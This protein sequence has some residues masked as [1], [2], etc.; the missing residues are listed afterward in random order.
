MSASDK[1]FE[2]MPKMMMAIMTAV[3]MGTVLSSLF[4]SSATASEET[5][6]PADVFYW[7]CPYCNLQFGTLDELIA[8]VA[9]MHP[10]SPQIQKIDL[11]WT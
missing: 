2:A 10:D 4:T 7:T 5:A 3:I 1:T 8:H 11:G 9:T 6:V